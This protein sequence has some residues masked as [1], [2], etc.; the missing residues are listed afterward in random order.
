MAYREALDLVPERFA[1]T[2][3]KALWSQA[4][5]TREREAFVARYQGK[6]VA[7]GIVEAANPGLN[8]F[9]VLDGVR[10]VSLL[11]DDSRPEVQDGMLGLLTRAADW[12]RERNRRV[13]VHYV[14]TKSVEYAERAVLADLGEGLIWIIS[15]ALLPE[16]LEHLCESTTP[17]NEG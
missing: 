10:I 15:S 1:L 8:L 13:F 2:T 4:Q 7:I 16:F 11:E 14:E 6:P 3:T 9:H 12:F 5:L 17:R